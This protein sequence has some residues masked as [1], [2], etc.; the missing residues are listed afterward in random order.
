MLK[1]G[2]WKWTKHCFFAKRPKWL[3]HSYIVASPFLRP[4][5]AWEAKVR[6]RYGEGWAELRRPLVVVTRNVKIASDF[7]NPV[8]P[9]AW[10]CP[11]ARHRDV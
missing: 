11:Q 7:N 4:F 10:P 3:R 5:S 6:R 8:S 9:V 2:V 1:S